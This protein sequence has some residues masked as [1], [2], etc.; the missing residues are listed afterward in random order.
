MRLHMLWNAVRWRVLESALVTGGFICA[1][2]QTIVH[3]AKKERSVGL[4]GLAHRR[5]S[6]AHFR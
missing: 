2:G 1:C 5:F 6:L 4:G 3:G